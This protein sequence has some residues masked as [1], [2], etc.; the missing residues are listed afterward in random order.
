MEAGVFRSKTK[1]INR[2]LVL[3]GSGVAQQ[4]VKKP[5]GV[6]TPEDA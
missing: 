1:N 4:L 6:K 2:S 3:V 5:G